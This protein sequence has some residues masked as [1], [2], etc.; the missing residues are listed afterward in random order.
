MLP[1]AFREVINFI[2]SNGK[3]PVQ[4]SVKGLKFGYMLHGMAT[5]TAIFIA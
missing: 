4:Q 1:I 2:N 3:N 5:N